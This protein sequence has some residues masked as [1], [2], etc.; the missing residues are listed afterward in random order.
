[1]AWTAPR[2]WV[3]GETVTAAL[4]NTHL[5]DNLL[6]VA[7]AGINGMAS[8][9]P[10]WTSSG[11][12]PAILNGS[13]AGQ[14]LQVG[15]TVFFEAR[16]T[17]GNTTTFGTGNYTWALPVTSAALGVG[18]GVG[19]INDAAALH[20]CHVDLIS[21]T[22]FTLYTGGTTQTQA[23]ATSPMTWADTDGFR[24]AGFYESAS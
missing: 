15:T 5:R 7:R 21:T 12:A 19:L 6:W 20:A 17:A 18:A 10:A 23:A 13:L 16:M 4:L 22:T 14:Y 11:T 24:V 3:A 1:M 2:T 9:E 8:F